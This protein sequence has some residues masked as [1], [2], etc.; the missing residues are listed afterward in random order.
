[1]GLTISKKSIP[2]FRLCQW[3]ERFVL[4]NSELHHQIVEPGQRRV[5]GVQL[6]QQ[7]L[8]FVLTGKRI[9]DDV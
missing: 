4:S 6:V 7:R 5:F 8:E 9:K 2:L 1:V 3:V